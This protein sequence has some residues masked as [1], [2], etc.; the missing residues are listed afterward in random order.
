MS[1]HAENDDLAIDDDDHFV[2][3]LDPNSGRQAH[4]N[5][6]ALRAR[7]LIACFFLVV[8]CGLTASFFGVE[9]GRQTNTAIFPLL[10]GNHT[11]TAVTSGN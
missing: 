8:T 9:M 11:S 7:L 4:E 10:F 2:I 3:G 5:D 6:I 1:E